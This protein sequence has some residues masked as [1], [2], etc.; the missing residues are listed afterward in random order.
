MDK[1]D[2]SKFFIE[3]PEREFYVR[4]IAKKLKKSPT[5]ISKY[6]KEFV[7]K[8]LLISE[9]K[10]NHLFFKANTEST[11]FLQLKI[12]YNLNKIQMSG[13]TGFLVKEFNHSEAI[14]LFGS[15]SRGE[16]NKNSDVDLFIVSSNKKELDLSIYEKK[17]GNR[18]QLFVYSKA[19][20]AKMKEKNK[21]LLNNIINGIKLYGFLEVLR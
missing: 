11:E 20:L 9:E 5:T 16:N 6:L 4:E 13:L 17:I 1:D 12:S 8:R 10:F 18:I 19:E 7:K 14:V 2:I 3:E 21:E 15:F